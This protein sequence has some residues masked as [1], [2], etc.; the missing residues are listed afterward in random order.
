VTTLSRTRSSCLRAAIVLATLAPLGPLAACSS[1]SSGASRGAGGA[2]GAPGSGGTGID[3]DAGP[4]DSG[5]G[6]HPAADP[7]TCEE[8]AE[9]KSYVGCDFWPTVLTNPVWDVFDFTVVV[10]NGGDQA[11][12]VT[13]ERA[14]KLVSGGAVPPKGLTK[15]HLPWVPELKGP[16]MNQC[17]DWTA[18]S[19]SLR[20]PDGAYHLVSSV[21]VTVYQFNPL[22][23]ASKGGPAGKDWSSC[24]G[25]LTCAANGWSYGC[26]SYSND[27]SLLLPTPALTGNYRVIGQR[28]WAKDGVPAYV[29]V[30]G[31]ADATKVT[32]SVSPTGAVAAGNGIAA[33]GGGQSLNLSLERGEVVEL[34]GTP[35]TDLAGTLIQSSAPVQVIAGMPC[36]N[37]PFDAYSC[38][39]IEE[40]VFPAETLGKRYFVT[41][42]TG[43]NGVAL[44]HMV[45]LVGNVDGTALTY[46][47]MTPANA[48]ASIDA[49]Q[50]VD[51]G[52]VTQDFE[53]VGSHE[54]AVASFQLGSSVVD[55]GNTQPRG[56][57]SQSAM[58]G[59]EQFRTQYVF[60]APHDYDVSYVDVVSPEGATVL[61]DGSA[62]L[63]PPAVLSNGYV[64]VRQ[65]LGPGIDGAHLIV[66]DMPV[67]IQVIGYGVA[68]SYQYPGGSNLVR[69]A[70]PPIK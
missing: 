31:T 21:P 46:F 38:D 32:V 3:L 59:V 58:I 49:G 37:L 28:G 24:P 23:Y 50:V 2:G 19:A 9:T 36:V 63:A 6:G 29:A 1:A 65:M 30:V 16:E 62:L 34:V 54:L 69:I 20:V 60:L 52:L 66:S 5:K 57:P 17:A 45:R 55:P 22:E 64:V 14:G 39:H 26:F 7:K 43:P 61:L 70:P 15:F 11:G 56:D 67:G 68:T 40:S 4:Q 48:P 47:G 12:E 10:A 51:L 33:A 44:G 35:S 41:R 18:P 42:P 8:A 25:H 27:A 13:I 53:V